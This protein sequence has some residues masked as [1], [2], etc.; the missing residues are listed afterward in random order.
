MLKKSISFALPELE[1]NVVSRINVSG[2]Y[3][4]VVEY[5]SVGRS[6]QKPPFS[7]SSKRAKQ[8]LESM[9]GMQHQ[10]IEPSREINADEWQ[11]DMKAYS[12]M[13]G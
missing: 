3:P 2:R 11:S 12:E 13:G 7:Q 6:W 1:W 4:R 5:E 10:S 9:R 8:L